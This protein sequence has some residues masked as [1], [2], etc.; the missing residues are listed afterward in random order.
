MINLVFI[1]LTLLAIGG[2]FVGVLANRTDKIVL[3]KRGYKVFAS[4]AMLMIIFAILINHHLRQEVI[5]RQ[6]EEAFQQR[7]EMIKKLLSTGETTFP[8]EF[9]DFHWTVG[10]LEQRGMI[11]PEEA[12]RARKVTSPGITIRLQPEVSDLELRQ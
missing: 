10:R 7:T 5:Q 9:V 6:H 2:L 11:T 8:G 4:S 1:L 12:E 3:A